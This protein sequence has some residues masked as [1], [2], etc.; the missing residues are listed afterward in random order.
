MQSRQYLSAILFLVAWQG[1]AKQP[2][3]IC[4]TGREGW[5][6]ELFLHQR[7]AA[8]RKALGLERRAS[9]PIGKDVG[10]IAVIY[11]G[12]GVVSR[13]NVFNLTGRG[14]TFTASGTNAAS[15]RF[16]TGASN[17]D[18]AAAESGVP[19]SGLQDDD[20]RRFAVGF[21]F[22]FFGKIYTEMWVNSDGNVSFEEGDSASVAKSIGL[23]SGGPPRIAPLLVDLDPSFS[24]KGVRVLAE[25]AR[26]VVTWLEVPEF[27][28]SGNGP[29]QTFQAKLFPDGRI[30]FA[31]VTANP[32]EAVTGISPGRSTGSTEI[33]SFQQGSG[34]EFTAT[35]AER[36]SATEAIDP[37]LLAQRFYETHDDAYDYLAVYN[38]MGIPAR[39][40]A[41]ATEVTVRSRFR[42]G[43][44]DIAVETGAQYGSARRLQAFLNMGTL[45]QYPRD[46][47]AAV[48][49]RSA[50]GD[51]PLSILAHE[52]GHLFLALASV[53][54][55]AN[56]EARPMLGSAQAHWSFNFNSEASFVEGNRIE[57]G[58]EN[59]SPRF[60]TVATAEQYSAL[61]QYL[62]GLRAPEE[63][64]PTFL[65]RGSGQLSEQQPRKGVSFNGA[66][67]NIT[68]QELI[69]AE[70]R[71]SP[72]HTV[73]QRRFRLAVIL[74]T[75]PD[76]EPAEADLAQVERLRS[77][78]EGYYARGTGNRA[79]METALR[80]NVQLSVWP[81]AGVLAGGAV[82]GS[83]TL[84]R[85]AV[86]PLTVLLRSESGAANVPASVTIA[87]GSRQASF[88]IQGVRPGVDR[89]TADTGDAQYVTDEARI[90][91]AAS[92][93]ELRLAVV[94]GDRQIATA[95]IALSSAVGIR[96]SDINLIPYPGVPVRAV[97]SAGGSVEPA[98]AV[99]GAD[100]IARFRWTPAAAAVNQLRATVEGANGP[101]VAS[102][103]SRPS[104][105]VPGVGNAAS[106]ARGLTPG[107]L[108]VLFGANLAAGRTASAASQPWPRSLG[109]VQLLING[110][111]VPLYYVS[112]EQI[113]FLIPIDLAGADGEIVVTNSLGRTDPARIPVAPLSPGLFFNSSTGEAAVRVAGTGLLTSQQPIRPG[114]FLEIYAT[115]LG[116]LVPGAGGLLETALR[117]SVLVGGEAAEVT[118]SG[119]TPGIPGLY[120]INARVSERIPAGVWKLAIELEGLRSNEANVTVG[121]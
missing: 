24:L 8:T 70:G 86:T 91:V 44:G 11:G 57:D 16:T 81:A 48:P 29:P 30:E 79:S 98:T 115:G 47:L 40:F 9:A 31:Y 109:G 106:F 26:V 56:P 36:F 107:A 93:G 78:F 15:Y 73:A 95:G 75:P 53:R 25:P 120:Q 80:K 116:P 112:D 118:F 59:A 77:E 102:A 101:A 74:L 42:E 45:T 119:Q 3:Q 68:I 35:V 14:I 92:A 63:V 111:P 54:D 76:T 121:R 69:E 83:V 23:M 46:P 18:A 37:L 99:T 22:P 66:R 114:E 27:R 10:N 13:R 41:V 43:F 21:R 4:G 17:Y 39:S 51:T 61:D 32:G 67:R 82:Q 49:A 6:E 60:S 88:P 34:S 28:A 85:P 50:A 12:D 89:I 103:L 113:N 104:F 108:G 84:D 19:I 117:P 105:T 62:M 33:V 58:G 94:E 20:T 38:T 2:P 110:A 96:V 71:R 72:D 65:V 90:H 5:K 87:A 52:V 100:G 55:E 97:V 1:I 7:A 64:P